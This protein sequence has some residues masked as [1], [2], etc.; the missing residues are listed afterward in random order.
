MRSCALVLL[1]AGCFT[2]VAEPCRSKLRCSPDGGED[3]CSVGSVRECGSSVG[4]CKPGRQTCGTDGTWGRCT[5]AVVAGVEVC[6][7]LDNNCDGVIDDGVSRACPLQKGVCAGASA[8]CSDAGATC[9]FAYGPQYQRVETRCD[10]LDN[11]CDGV[12]DRSAPVNVSRSAGVVSRRPVAV[13]VPGG[14]SVLVLYEEGEKVAARV[15][16]ADGTLSDPVPPSV[17]VEAAA[18]A[19]LPAIAASGSLIV[20][21]W[22]EELPTTKRVMV[23]SLDPLTGR[24]NLTGGG[25]LLAMTVMNPTEVA[26]AVDEAAGRLVLAVTDTP[27]VRLSGFS[28]TLPPPMG[29]PAFS[30]DPYDTLGRRTMLAPAGGGAFTFSHDRTDG[31]IRRAFVTPSGMTP[32]EGSLA[33]GQDPSFFVFDGG[34]ASAYLAGG[35]MARQLFVASCTLS[36]SVTCQNGTPLTTAADIDLLEVSQFQLAAWQ[37][38]V[39]SPRVFSMWLGRSDAGIDLAPGR[40]PMP[41]ATP[42]R[43]LVVFDTEG[44]TA[45]QVETDEVYLMTMCR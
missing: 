15:L 38:G 27:G 37:A 36:T 39:A 7:G 10:G 4:T 21:A 33:M 41:I 13:A 16:K 23:A 22:A 19:S 44:V 40:R 30:A 34:V 35:A 28:S 26:V 43:G 11:D 20:A 5:G 9:D 8:G 12:V 31:R 32:T 45:T 1:L 6:D 24:S 25:A 14:E 2:P 17:T 42:Q 29:S 3:R 18:K